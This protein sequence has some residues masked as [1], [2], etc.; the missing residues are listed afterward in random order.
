MNGSS[1]LLP[2]MIYIIGIGKVWIAMALAAMV[3][4]GFFT[5]VVSMDAEFA[6]GNPTTIALSFWIAGTAIFSVIEIVL[7]RCGRQTDISH[8]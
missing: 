7:I 1:I 4:F 5:V 8:G 6:H 3:L 2:S